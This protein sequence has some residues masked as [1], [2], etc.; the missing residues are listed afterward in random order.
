MRLRFVDGLRIESHTHPEENFQSSTI[1]LGS[2]REHITN[3]QRHTLR[4]LLWDSMVLGKSSQR[5]KTHDWSA[6]STIPHYRAHEKNPCNP[7]WL[8]RDHFSGISIRVVTI[9]Q[10]ETTISTVCPAMI[11]ITGKTSSAS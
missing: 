3:S 7:G 4:R 6:N 8:I 9:S 5:V 1:S 10:R 2:F 11:S